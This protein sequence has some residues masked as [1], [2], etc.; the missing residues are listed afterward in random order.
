VSWD[1]STTEGLSG[2]GGALLL[3]V[4]GVFWS[5]MW[6]IGGLLPFGLFAAQRRRR[7]IRP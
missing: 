7:R 2:L 4:C 1:D 3:V 6:I 5:L